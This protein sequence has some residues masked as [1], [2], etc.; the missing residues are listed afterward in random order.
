MPR[1][2]ETWVEQEWALENAASP[3]QEINLEYNT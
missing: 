3:I 2:R 1:E